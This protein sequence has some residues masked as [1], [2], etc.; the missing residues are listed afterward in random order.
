M[1]PLLNWSYAP[2][3][4]S[5]FI[6]IYD[7][8][9]LQFKTHSVLLR[10]AARRAGPL[11][12][13]G[14]CAQRRQVAHPHRIGLPLL[15]LPLANSIYIPATGSARGNC[16]GLRGTELIS[17]QAQ[18]VS[19]RESLWV[20]QEIN[21]LSGSR[22]TDTEQDCCDGCKIGLHLQSIN[23]RP[24]AACFTPVNHFISF[25]DDFYQFNCR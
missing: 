11:D 14:N 17:H 10:L 19:N 20:P 21:P 4:Y 12:S 8:L 22:I 23:S 2:N 16:G 9:Q 25:P 18:T 7:L 5:I 13:F 3:C 24:I 15:G 6:K 1:L